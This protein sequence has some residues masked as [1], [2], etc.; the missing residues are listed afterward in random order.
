VFGEVSYNVTQPLKLTAGLRW[1]QV[2][3]TSQG[4]EEGLAVGGGEIVSPLAT[5]KED[6]VTPKFEAD[7][8]LTRDKMVYAVVSKGF[9]PG[10]VVPI[11]PP[12]T[13]G[14]AN[15]CVAALAAVNPN[16]TLD[17]TRSFKSDALWNYEVG[18]K[19]AWLDRR[20]ILNVSAFD[21]RWKNIQQE[22]LLQCGFQYVANAGAAESK[23]AEM[24]F[25]AQATEHLDLS[26]GLG[27]QDAKI[28]QGG[29]SPQPV[30]SPVF[31]VPDWTGNASAVYTV[32][33]TADWSLM[34][35]LDYSYMGSSFSSSNSSVSPRKRPAYRLVDL[36][37]ALSNGTTELALV[38]KNLTD[39]VTNLGDNR[40]IAAE[41]PGRPRLFINQP[42]TIGLE[43]RYSF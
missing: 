16:I 31:Q 39:E 10:G 17:Q 33:V 32:P 3:T 18:A 21:I 27:Y 6:G 14:T 28:T 20:A 42:R 26:L 2:K 13:P 4:F 9:R 43:A 37:I 15:D 35:E 11:V 5:D 38:G 25:R 19:T 40:S 30:G 36:R 41:V 22:V 12:G 24:E 34:N 29:E 23:G 1:Y 8:S 7:Y